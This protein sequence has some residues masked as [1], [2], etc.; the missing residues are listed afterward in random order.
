MK[1]TQENII[2]GSRFLAT[3]C[4][5]LPLSVTS[6]QTYLTDTFETETIG[7][8]PTAAIT[9]RPNTNTPTNLI[10]VVDGIDNLAGTGKGVRIFD[11]D[12][13]GLAA[14]EY[15]F[16]GSAGAQ[17]SAVQISFDFAGGTGNTDGSRYINV[18]AGSFFDGS[19]SPRIGSSTNRI[20]DVRLYGDGD[21]RFYDGSASTNFV[22]GAGVNTITMFVN[23]FETAIS[24]IDP[25]TLLSTS[26][27]ANTVAYYLFDGTDYFTS[28]GALNAAI[29]GGTENNLGRFGMT[30]VSTTV[31]VDYI[32]DNITVSAIP[33]PS[34]FALLAGALA[35]TAVMLR[36]RK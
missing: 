10:T 26:L 27:A 32:V 25:D 14:L 36:R 22:S 4:L 23:D 33:E 1:K 13:T 19:S 15:N 21:V 7:N 16:V 20:F 17:V 30:S 28:T 5:L 8:K 6:A 35:L 9:V 2:G 12:A 11:N 3:A 34:T 31:G 24:Y 18:G 29:A